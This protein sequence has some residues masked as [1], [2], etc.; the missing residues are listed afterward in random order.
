MPAIGTILGPRGKMPEQ[1]TS[2]KDV[3]QIIYKTPGRE[4]DSPCTGWAA[5]YAILLIVQVAS[6]WN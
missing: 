5:G 6:F 4:F 3:V 1:L 2:D